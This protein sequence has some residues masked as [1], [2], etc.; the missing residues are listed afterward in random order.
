MT[1]AFEKW[2]AQMRATH[3]NSVRFSR[4]ATGFIH[5]YIYRG[6]AHGPSLGVFDEGSD[7]EQQPP[8]VSYDAA[9]PR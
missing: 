9:P 2:K 8:R 5:A 1:A 6:I 4:S 7:T 3:G